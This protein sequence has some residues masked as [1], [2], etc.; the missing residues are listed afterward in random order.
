MKKITTF[1]FSALLL[2]MFFSV[3][4][5]AS[6]VAPTVAV[7]AETNVD[8]VSTTLNG[9]VNPNSLATDAW[10]HWG[11]SNVACASLP[12]STSSQSLGSGAGNV[13]LTAALTG[14]VPGV[15]YYYCAVASNASGVT[16][17]S[18]TSFTQAGGSGCQSVSLTD[19]Y[20]AS[21]SC[22]FGNSTVDGV[23]KG[24]GT[25]NDAVLTVAKGTTLTVGASQTVAYGSI[26][27][28]GATVVRLAGGN[29]RRGPVWVPDAD[30]DGYPDS[31]GTQGQVVQATQPA[32]YARR[33]V[34]AGANK[35]C[36]SS[37]AAKFKNY[38]GF[39][40]ADADGYGTTAV[41]ALFC[42]GSTF[43]NGT[44][45]S[46]GV[47]CLDSN[48]NVFANQT[49]A[50]DADQDASSTSTAASACAG[51]STTVSGRTY[52]KDTA[53]AYSF[54]ASANIAN[55][56]DCLDSNANIYQNV[57]VGTD[58][59]Q[60]GY[61][62]A[63]AGSV[64][65]GASSTVSGRTYYVGS[66]GTVNQI[67]AASIIATSDCLDSNA[68]VQTDKTTY[69]DT[70]GDTFTAAGATV[71]LTNA[72][73][74]S[75]GCATDYSKDASSVCY[76]TT[77]A[78]AD[79]N[80]NIHNTYAYAWAENIGWINLA[81]CNGGT[82]IVNVSSSALTG[83][84][85]SENAGWISFNCSNTSSCGTTNYSVA[86]T[87]GVLSGYAW[88]E[89]IGWISFNCS[90]TSTCGT[91]NYGVSIDATGAWSGY[92][93]SENAGWISFNCSNTSSCGTTNYYIKSAWTSQ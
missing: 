83:Y 46:S 32:G 24:T 71:C 27:K 2:I 61:S 51:A 91:V 87:A 22:V 56:S 14:F 11:P 41:Q 64:C 82:S 50:T 5:E 47:D 9:T 54:I 57:S 49:V 70:D 72:T 39:T 19:D 28:P 55:T 10:Y 6:A 29:L 13:A 77:S 69:V 60:D 52:Y 90:N 38:V 33:A 93:W 65:V 73:G 84:T 59:D 63:A 21:S 79:C 12:N 4:Q 15:T 18:V 80:D 25:Q 86:N 1:L 8:S 37:D 23:D 31:V 43:V 17:S 89:N 36:D 75:V 67:A 42:S 45:S 53:G 76:L 35:D 40:D 44:L 7:S 78:G 48:A 58:A 26:Y 68:T 62:T 81:S 3:V 92:A 66:T 85:W 16:Y 30:G 74:A 34:I 88:A 20:T